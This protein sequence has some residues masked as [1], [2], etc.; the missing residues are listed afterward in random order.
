MK[1]KEKEKLWL[2]KVKSLSKADG[3]KFKAFFIYKSIDDLFFSASF[4]VSRNE[5]SISGYLGYKT[6]NIDNVF[7][8]IID[9]QPNKKM[10]LSFRGNAAFCVRVVN[11]MKYKIDNVDEL[12][13]DDKIIELLKEID[14]K[15]TQKASVI[16]T[17]DDFHCELLSDE[18]A[19]SVGIVTA[20]IEL[21]QIDNA[22][23]KIKEY[24]A[25]DFNSGFRFGDKDFYD[26]AKEYCE[27]NYR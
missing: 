3:W 27:K 22:L 4:Y 18:K 9:E 19:N 2:T 5:N 16:K 6:Y 10:P 25:N 21:G 15:S 23:V 13:P 26:L 7:W 8:D 20:L 11:V 12:T 14:F 1:Y 17:L 24:K